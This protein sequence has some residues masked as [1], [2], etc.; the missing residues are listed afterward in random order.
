MPKIDEN[1]LAD[2]LNGLLTE[3]ILKGENLI[4]QM[5]Q[6]VNN[7]NKNVDSL[8]NTLS[9]RTSEIQELIKVLKGAPKISKA[10]KYETIF[11]CVLTGIVLASLFF[12]YSLSTVTY[13]YIE[14]NLAHREL[15][16]KYDELENYAI[17]LK[18]QNEAYK[19][20]F[21]Q[22]LTPKGRE[23]FSE[24]FSEELQKLEKEQ[25]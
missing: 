23:R 5:N 21:Q 11:I 6:S 22:T 7:F 25:Q 15:I 14:S 18:N 10:I 20:T 9:A 1:K 4:Q 17:L 13:N 19:R 12:S 2:I 3:S 8:T 24:I 16:K